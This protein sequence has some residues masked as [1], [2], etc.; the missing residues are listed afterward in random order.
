MNT[1]ERMKKLGITQ[2]EMIMKLR[3][4][5]INVSPPEMSATLRGLYTY[6]KATKVLAECENIM[7]EMK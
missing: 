2:V 7:N 3:E 5:G 4:R 1:K 6:P